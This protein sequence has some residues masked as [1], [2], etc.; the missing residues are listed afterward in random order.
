MHAILIACATPWQPSPPCC[1]LSSSHC[2]PLFLLSWLPYLFPNPSSSMLLPSSKSSEGGCQNPTPMLQN[3]PE[4]PPRVPVGLF[5]VVRCLRLCHLPSS[6][7]LH[8]S[9]SLPSSFFLFSLFLFLFSIFLLRSYLV[10]LMPSLLLA[11]M[12]PPSLFLSSSSLF[13]SSTHHS[14][15]YSSQFFLLE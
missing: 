5:G 11:C 15:P 13:F 7:S 6:P 4:T 3:P 8:C 10:T 14:S 1:P 12:N 9:T 2:A